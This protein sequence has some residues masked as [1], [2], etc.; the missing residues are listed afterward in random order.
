MPMLN[1]F[2]DDAMAF[3]CFER[4]LQRVKK[5]FRHDEEGIKYGFYRGSHDIACKCIYVQY[6]C[7]PRLCHTYWTPISF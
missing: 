4:L 1:T 6:S 7:R 5:N 2:E 3:W